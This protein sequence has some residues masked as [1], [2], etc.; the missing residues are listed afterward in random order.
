M[1]PCND[2]EAVQRAAATAE[3]EAVSKIE[4]TLSEILWII[5]ARNVTLS[6]LK[7]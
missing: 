2:A 5:S 7:G 1:N 6:K 3:A 4:G